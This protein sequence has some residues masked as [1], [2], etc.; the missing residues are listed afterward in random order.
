MIDRSPA[1][2]TDIEELAAKLD[3][4]VDAALSI[5]VQ[6]H[7]VERAAS[8]LRHLSDALFHA[9]NTVKEPK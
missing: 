5:G 6:L 1:P 9:Q 4:M 3:E 7:R 8:M 2:H